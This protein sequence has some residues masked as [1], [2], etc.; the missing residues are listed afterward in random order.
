M[1]RNTEISDYLK[2]L[3]VSDENLR[4]EHKLENISKFYSHPD[5]E[6]RRDALYLIKLIEDHE[7]ALLTTSKKSLYSRI[8]EAKAF[9]RT[10]FHRQI[11]A[12]AWRWI[13]AN[14]KRLR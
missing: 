2:F 13:S 8:E 5:Y 7:L 12:A 6:E 11:S 10:C 14:E 4:L 3:E 1:L 9:A